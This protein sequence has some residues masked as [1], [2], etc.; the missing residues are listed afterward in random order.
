MKS[1]AVTAVGI[2]LVD[3]P[4]AVEPYPL[5]GVRRTE[6]ESRPGAPLARLAVAKVNPI[7]LTCGD[8]SKQAAVALPGSF[9]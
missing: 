8:Y 4:L 1:N 9:H 6:M 3:L 7:R 5:F 2:A